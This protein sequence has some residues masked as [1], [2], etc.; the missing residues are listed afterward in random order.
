MLSYFR[1]LSGRLLF[2]IAVFALYCA[3]H[4]AEAKDQAAF[5]QESSALVVAPQYKD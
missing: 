1:T 2:G 4:G 5:E 3:V